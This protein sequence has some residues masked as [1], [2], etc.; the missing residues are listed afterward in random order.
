MD[1]FDFC[2]LIR[3]TLSA[4]GSRYQ[5]PKLTLTIRVHI[6]LLRVVPTSSHWLTEKIAISSHLRTCYNHTN[7]HTPRACGCIYCVI[8]LEIARCATFVRSIEL[9]GEMCSLYTARF[10]CLRQI[11]IVARGVWIT[12]IY[13]RYVVRHFLV[14]DTF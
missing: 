9:R 12:I 11:V 6:H 7:T 2:F 13:C 1:R 8:R 10:V 3:H 5:T 14:T 4:R